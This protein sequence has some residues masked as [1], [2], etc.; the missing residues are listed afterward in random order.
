V[1]KQGALTLWRPQR[2]GLVRT[3][4]E[5][6]RA[7][8][9]H[10]LETPEG[11]TCQ[12]TEGKRLSK[13]HSQSGGH[14]GRDL[15]GHERKGIERGTLTSWRPQ[16]EGPVRTR[17]ETDRARC[18]HFLQTAEGGTCHDKKGK[19]LSEVHSLPGDNRGRDMSGH[20]RKVTEQ[21]TLTIWRLQREGLVRTW[22]ESDRVR[23]THNLETAEGGTCQDME[24][25]RLSK[26]HSQSGDCRGRD[27]SGHE[28]KATE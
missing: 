4:K 18:T 27:L 24:G 20:E 1:I 17:K 7:R 2:E 21:G 14:R 6:D 3:R 25:K 28:R 16:R 11:G 12:D 10:N 13:A 15:S 19:R 8:C 26:A 23:H 5:S 22:K 9:T